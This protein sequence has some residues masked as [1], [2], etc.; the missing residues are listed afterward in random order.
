[1]SWTPADEEA[2]FALVEH[3]LGLAARLSGP[4][5]PGAT[6]GRPR[7]GRPPA[8]AVCYIPTAV[9]DAQAAIDFYEDKFAARPARS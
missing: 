4:Q 5:G 6:A 3:A 9:G 7:A 8:D 2:S 1:M